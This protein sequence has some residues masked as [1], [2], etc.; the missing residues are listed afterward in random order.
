MKF[1]Q[2]MYHHHLVKRRVKAPP[3]KRAIK[4]SETSNNVHTMCNTTPDTNW[5]ECR[6]NTE[7]IQLDV[8]NK[9]VSNT[10]SQIR[11]APRWSTACLLPSHHHHRSPNTSWV[12]RVAKYHFSGIKAKSLKMFLSQNITVKLSYC[13]K[14]ISLPP[15]F[16]SKTTY[17]PRRWWFIVIIIVYVV[18]SSVMLA[19]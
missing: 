3:S 14:I 4:R 1:S 16:I 6:G 5:Q 10:R 7:E 8:R 13:N 17:Q 12:K 19:G 15:S 9:T 18:H 11:S 2:C